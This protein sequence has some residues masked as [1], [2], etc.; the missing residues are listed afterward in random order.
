MR[1]GVAARGTKWRDAGSRRQ[2]TTADT[3]PNTPITA[4]AVRHELQSVIS[5]P[6]KR[7]LMPPR[8]LPAM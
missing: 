5:A 7:P 8:A 4:S 3:S 6:T 2:N 1:A